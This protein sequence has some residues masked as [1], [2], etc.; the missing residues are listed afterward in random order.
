MVFDG[1]TMNT[2]L[3]ERIS[4][5]LEGKEIRFSCEEDLVGMI[6]EDRPALPK[7]KV[8]FRRKIHRKK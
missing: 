2:A 6:W 1:R 5:K 4:K 8:S 3:V 7:E